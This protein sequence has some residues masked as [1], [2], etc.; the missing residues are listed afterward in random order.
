[1]STQQ[2]SCET[3]S[4]RKFFEKARCAHEAMQLG[5]VKFNIAAKYEHL[6]AI[7]SLLRNEKA[8][9]KISADQAKFELRE[10]TGQIEQICRHC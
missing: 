1:M 4:Q 6:T 8:D 2:H 5:R 3:D 9:F 10:C 7:S